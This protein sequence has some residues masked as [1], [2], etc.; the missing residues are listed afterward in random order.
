[1]GPSAWRVMESPATDLLLSSPA[2][3]CIILILMAPPN[4]HQLASE[5]KRTQ[6]LLRQKLGKSS[7]L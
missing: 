6:A 7:F 3:L 1:M 4:P 5:G 2:R